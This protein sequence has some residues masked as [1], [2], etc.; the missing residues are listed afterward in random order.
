MTNTNNNQ[1]YKYDLDDDIYI[2]CN[3]VDQFGEEDITSSE[4]NI[5]DGNFGKNILDDLEITFNSKG[6]MENIGFQSLF[7]I[8]IFA[9][10]YFIGDYIFKQMPKQLLDKKIDNS[11][12]NYL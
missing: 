4:E 7:G 11:R 8:T 6:V 3:P 2:E 5:M 12:S 9:I 1:S 10:I